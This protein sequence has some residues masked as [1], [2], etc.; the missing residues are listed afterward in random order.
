MKL[1]QYIKDKWYLRKRK[2]QLEQAPK[3]LGDAIMA[4]DA[5]MTDAQR[6]MF[7]KEPSDCPGAKF[8]FFGG[9]AMRNDWGLWNK[10]QPL[11][12]WFRARG[13]W[14][15]DDM[16]AIIYKAYWCFLNDVPFCLAKEA[17]YYEKFWTNCGI[18]FDGVV[19]PN[20]F[21]TGKPKQI[22]FDRKGAQ[23]NIETKK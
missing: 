14:H 21:P 4:F 20:Y 23:V 16:S 6:A 11:T 18:G 12:Q 15:A 17:E 13:I 19:I 2:K 8:H 10:E 9:M 3:D 7:A 22:T 5:G 1:F